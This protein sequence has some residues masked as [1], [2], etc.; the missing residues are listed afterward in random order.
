[1]ARWK[2]AFGGEQLFEDRLKMQ[3]LRFDQSRNAAFCRAVT[4]Q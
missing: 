2:I 3:P 1:M 4:K